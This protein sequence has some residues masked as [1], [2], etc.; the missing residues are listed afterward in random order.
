[1]RCILAGFHVLAAYFALQQMPLSVQKMILSLKPVFTI[2]FERIFLKVPIGVVEIVTII[3]MGLG[4][5]L[6]LQPPFIFNYAYTEKDG[7][8]SYFFVST[9]LVLV[10][11]ALNSNVAIIIRYLRKLPVA[12]LTSSREIVYVIITFITIFLIDVQLKTPNLMDKLKIVMIGVF[13]LVTQSL[14]I[15][16]L[17]VET[18]SL[19]AVVDRSSAIVIA[20]LTQIIFFELIPNSFSIGGM[21]LVLVAGVLQSGWKY[22]KEVKTK[23]R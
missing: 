13:C 17:K 12:S 8:E 19:V 1:M 9:I 14:T 6:V 20:V 15:V 7:F 16:A 11:T 18:A 4:V 5:V 22:Y 21:I 2:I 10:S 3:V 23:P